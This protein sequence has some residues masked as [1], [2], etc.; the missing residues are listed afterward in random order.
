MSL[1]GIA[2]KAGRIAAGEFQTEQ[3]V[4]AGKAHLVLISTDASQNTKKKFRNMCIFYEVPVALY[5]TKEELGMAVGCEA[6]ASLAVL[7]RGLAD[8][9][10]GKLPLAE[11]ENQMRD[12][13][14]AD[15]ENQG[16]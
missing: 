5:S 11:S 4:K 16:A 7:D 14:R 6:R 1:V 13:G 2:K 12:G 9:I 8:S 3:A 10:Y 15:G